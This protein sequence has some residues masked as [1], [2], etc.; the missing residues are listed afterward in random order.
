MLLWKE[1]I[2]EAHEPDYP[3]SSSKDELK[4]LQIYLC[5][6]F[7]ITGYKKEFRLV[8]MDEPDV[9]LGLKLPTRDESEVSAA[10]FL[11]AVR[12]REKQLTQS[13]KG[14]PELSFEPLLANLIKE[15]KP[16]V[17]EVKLLIFAIL[18][19]NHPKAKEVMR[20]LE[21]NEFGNSVSAL[22]RAMRESGRTIAAAL[23]QDAM[24]CQIRLLEEP[25]QNSDIWD[26]VEA[27][28]LL[29]QL[30]VATSEQCDAGA[31]EDIEQMLFKHICPPGPA[32]LHSIADFRG[33]PDL[34]L[35]QDY[36][37]DAL[38][39]K[40][41]GKNI[42]LYGKPG[43]GKTQLA[44][45]LAEKL[46]AP[47][48]EVPTKDSHSGAMTGRVRLDAA[49]MA[50]MFLEDRL[51][52]ILMFDEME[53]AFRKSDQL[54]KG[55]FN[56]ML[57]ENRAPVIWISNNISAVDPAFLRRFDFIVEIEGT[58]SDRQADKLK[59]TLSELPVAPAW[60][61]E[62]ARK[63]WMTPALAR[64]IAEVGRYLPQRQIMR[65][66]Q[67]LESMVRQRLEV[68]GE[69][70]PGRILPKAQKSDFPEFRAEWINTKPTLWNVERFVRE[71][72]SARICLY[73]PP[74]AGK[75]A[76]A[77]ELAKCLNKPFMLQSGSDL[78]GMYVGQTEKNI[79]E[80]FDKAERSGAV[81]LL[82]EADTFL[83]S[84]N[85]THRSWEISAVNEF[86]VRLERFEGVLLA[87]TNRF[88]SFDKA[89]LRR[90]QMKVEFGYLTPEQVKAILAACVVDSDKTNNLTPSELAELDHLTPGV[91]R[92]A[93]QNLRLRGFRPRT[94]RL[95]DALKEE[96]R[97]QTEGLLSQPIGFVQ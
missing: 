70:I 5:R 27:G 25:N 83:Y 19:L 36:L 42:L 23:D 91:M 75:T 63:R 43:T 41:R 68:M 69:R 32:A 74:G 33:I 10:V 64:N 93:V 58:G 54:A 96:Q 89:I 97:Q 3:A 51:G 66:Q 11:E 94:G 86:M 39:N 34:Q 76:Y 85:M 7:L 21:I 45:A 30:V 65:N 9:F 13:L 52:A 62:V 56:Q 81:L 72:G 18:L 60:V 50:Q 37:Q 44:R 35:M 61:S 6:L 8:G 14:K 31:T 48:Y 55:W 53:D 2:N 29:S 59:Q 95:L 40:S 38:N 15:L 20:D 87:T 49:K 67:R 16:S 4:L 77:Q 1:L 17:V 24:L 47:L 28:P 22:A 82:D 92:A 80:M 78:L 88:D 46:G 73:G 26:L 57:E 71:E 84:R 90:F 79:A 12:K